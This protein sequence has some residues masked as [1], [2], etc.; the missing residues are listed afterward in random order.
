MRISIALLLVAAGT[1]VAAPQPQRRQVGHTASTYSIVSD[2]VAQYTA[3]DGTLDIPALFA[4]SAVDTPI[5]AP[6]QAAAT[7]VAVPT[8]SL[9]SE[10]AQASRRAVTTDEGILRRATSPTWQGY[11]TCGPQ[12]TGQSIYNPVVSPDDS[13]SSF[14]SSSYL[15]Q[16]AVTSDNPS[17]WTKVYQ[18]L[19]GVAQAT[20]ASIFLGSKTLTSY[21]PQSCA[22]MCTKTKGCQSFNIYF[23]RDPSIKMDGVDLTKCNNPPSVTTVGCQVYGAPITAKM[24]TSTGQVRGN[25]FRTAKAGSNGYILALL[26]PP[27]IDGYTGT[28]FPN[29]VVDNKIGHPALISVFNAN[30]DAAASGFM[31][32]L[33]ASACTKKAACVSAQS[34]AQ[35]SCLTSFSDSFQ[36]QAGFDSA[37]QYADGQFQGTL[38]LLYSKVFT[39]ADANDPGQWR[40][41]E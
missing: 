33:C 39:S 1:I 40:N 6:P 17:G 10:I 14:Q 22:D 28:T 41:G 21:D 19:N 18:G 25:Y 29:G 26:T 3:A 38:C 16:I 35:A 12:L 11:P 13:V 32:S 24:A 20:A 31:P 5:Q 8:A 34:R 9:A 36:L 2:S 7:S 23:E 4:D 15:K 37:P 27:S 30:S